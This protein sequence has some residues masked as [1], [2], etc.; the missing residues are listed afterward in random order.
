MH[1]NTYTAL[2]KIKAKNKWENVQHFQNATKAQKYVEIFQLH[3]AWYLNT[4]T[5]K[6]WHL[7]KCVQ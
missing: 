2:T 3:S 6:F 7:R 5:S 1:R 4:V